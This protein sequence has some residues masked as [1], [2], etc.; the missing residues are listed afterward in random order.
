MFSLAGF[1]VSPIGR[2]AGV[3]RGA[4]LLLKHSDAVARLAEI[5]GLGVDSAQQIIAEV[6]PEAATFATAGNMASWVG[7]CPG[8]EESAAVSVSDRSPKGN[9]AM[10]RVLNQCANAAVK[11][12]GSAFEVYYS[13]VVPRLG[14][15]KAVWSVAHKLCTVTWIVLHKKESY[16]EL[17]PRPNLDAVRKRASRLATQLRRMGY[18]VISPST[19]VSA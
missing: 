13:R 6:G 3:P 12:K 5:P 1:L 10:R 15:N 18:T 16:K 4:E 8:R 19:E 14:H 2:N 17:G 11:A 7:V 9:Q